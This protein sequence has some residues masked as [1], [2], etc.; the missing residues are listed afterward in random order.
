MHYT[1]AV[2]K[3]LSSAPIEFHH[4]HAIIPNKKLPIPN[5]AFPNPSSH[6]NDHVKPTIR[7]NNLPKYRF[8]I[9]YLSSLG[10]NDRGSTSLGDAID[11]GLW[12]ERCV[13]PEGDNVD[14]EGTTR[15]AT[16]GF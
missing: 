9:Q 14:A 2:L 15:R 8:I 4:L 7:S 3:S 13:V 5:A 16:M 12:F 11:E 10:L 1:T 6:I